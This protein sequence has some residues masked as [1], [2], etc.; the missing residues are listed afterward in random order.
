L[1]I[2][3]QDE[4]LWT[5]VPP[6]EGVLVAACTPVAAVAG[7]TPVLAEPPQAATAALDAPRA[8]AKTSEARKAP[9]AGG[10]EVEANV[11][12]LPRDGE[13]PRQKSFLIM[14]LH[15]PLWRTSRRRLWAETGS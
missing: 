8:T 14:V 11:F 4:G 3:G 13:Q 7:L 1:D 15:T 6:A 10:L 2:D 9:L 5:P 12:P